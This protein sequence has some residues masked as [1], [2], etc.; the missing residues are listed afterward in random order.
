MFLKI[1][2]KDLLVIMLCLKF[3]TKKFR[4]DCYVNQ[5][6]YTCKAKKETEVQMETLNVEVVKEHS[7]IGKNIIK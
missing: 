7:Y 5:T 1:L 3:V 4:T 6:N 2:N